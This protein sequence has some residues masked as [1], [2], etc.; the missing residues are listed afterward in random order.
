MK[1][2]FGK[3]IPLVLLAAI[4]SV[5]ACSSDPK[6]EKGDRPTN[7]FKNGGAL[8]GAAKTQLSA[9][10]LKLEAGELYKSARKSLESGDYA[11]AELRYTSLSQRYPF[12]EYATQAELEKVYSL[13]KSYKPDEALTAADRFLR[14]HPRYPAADYVQYLKGVI[15]SDRDASLIDAIP[16]L[17]PSQGDTS[18]L[19]RSFDEFSLLLQK[20]PNS[21][22][23]AD[24]RAR[25]ADLRNRLAAHEMH[26]V[27]YYVKRGAFLAA[28]KRAEQVVALYPGAPATVDALNYLRISYQQLGLQQ[29]SDDA[30]ALYVQQTGSVAPPPKRSRFSQMLSPTAGSSSATPAAAPPA[31]VAEPAAAAP[32][33]AQGPVGGFFSRIASFFSFADNSNS[34]PMEVVIPSASKT[35]PAA[36][37]KDD[38]SAPADEKKSKII[39]E[40]NTGE[41]EKPAQASPAK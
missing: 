6:K 2:V 3:I 36:A 4:V 13:H 23:N 1:S 20:Y 16:F 12:T 40:I 25:M 5:S 26:V 15:N 14:E 29:Q 18:N 35:E 34:K 10:D 21:G 38:G 33:P 31:Y 24:A 37:A 11:D 39:V 19:R 30:N 9:R 27:R 17:D 32:K 41:D 8:D 22:Y 28:T 7:P